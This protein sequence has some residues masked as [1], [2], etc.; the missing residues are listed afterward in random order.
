M[1]AWELEETGCLSKADATMSDLNIDS[2]SIMR[3]D[4]WLENGEDVG[5]GIQGKWEAKNDIV[6]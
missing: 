2:H 1:A 5:D 4:R 3:K 6:R